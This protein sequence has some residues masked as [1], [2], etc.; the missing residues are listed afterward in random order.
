[1]AEQIIK[2]KSEDG[3]LYDTQVE[4][5]HADMINLIAEVL[6]RGGTEED[7]E[8]NFEEGAEA[9]LKRFEITLRTPK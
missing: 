7:G 4:A 2:W 9:L 5:E 3:C 8:F 1:M 6:H